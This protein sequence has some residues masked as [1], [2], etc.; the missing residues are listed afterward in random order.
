MTGSNH[1]VA[2]AVLVQGDF[3]SSRLLPC[4]T[5]REPTRGGYVL[6]DRLK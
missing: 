1:D 3:S 6:D 2:D 5:T 4:R